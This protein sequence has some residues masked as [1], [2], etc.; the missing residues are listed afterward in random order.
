[1]KATIDKKVISI[2]FVC[3]ILLCLFSGC[4]EIKSEYEIPL[5]YDDNFV[6]KIKVP[7][8]TVFLGTHGCTILDFETNLSEDEVKEFYNNYFSSLQKVYSMGHNP[9]DLDYYYD[10]NQRM[11]FY[12]LTCVDRGTDKLY[13]MITCDTCDNINNSEYWTTNKPNNQQ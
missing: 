5:S 6:A 9:E 2:L 1:M 7:E 13:F 11:V 10:K 4:D 8:N 3:S 12:D